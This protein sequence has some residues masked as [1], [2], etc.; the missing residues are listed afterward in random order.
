MIEIGECDVSCYLWIDWIGLVVWFLRVILCREVVGKFIK[1]M[2]DDGFE[3]WYV[4][5]IVF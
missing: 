4:D 2:F 5:W 1:M 3:L